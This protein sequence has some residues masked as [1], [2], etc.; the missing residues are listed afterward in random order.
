MSDLLS[1]YRDKTPKSKVPPTTV[2]HV[3]PVVDQTQHTPEEPISD[4]MR[5][6]IF[7]EASLELEALDA[8][9]GNFKK[10]A[11]SPK[12][13]SVL[14]VFKSH[15]VG[16]KEMKKYFEE[17]Y[18]KRLGPALI[19]PEVDLH[20]YILYSLV[21]PHATCLELAE[22]CADH[23]SKGGDSWDLLSSMTGFEMK[24]RGDMVNLIRVVLRRYPKVM[25]FFIP[26][27]QSIKSR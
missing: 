10:L 22:S 6:L 7:S 11:G 23:D 3:E 27:S 5:E 19:D 14:F 18:L 26:K 4:E 21:L 8:Y 25:D 15:K 12:P 17:V 9:W 24:D 2:S 1:R 16:F 13:G 20:T